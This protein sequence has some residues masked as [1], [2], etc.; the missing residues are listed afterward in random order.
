[1]IL[2]K[3]GLSNDGKALEIAFELEP[4]TGKEISRIAIQDHNHYFMGFPDSPQFQIPD[5]VNHAIQIVDNQNVSISVPLELLLESSSVKNTGMFFMYIEV[6]PTVPSGNPD[7]N[8]YFVA[9][10]ANVYPIYNKAVKLIA[11]LSNDCKDTENRKEVLDIYWKLETFKHSITLAD[12]DFAIKLYN[13]ALFN[14]IYAGDC[15]NA[16]NEYNFTNH[17]FTQYVTGCKTC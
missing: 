13:S 8:E 4:A 6:V 7:D 15:L 16:C 2:N 12:F 11:A 9:A 3:F 10:T 1:M 14:D 17:S 5:I